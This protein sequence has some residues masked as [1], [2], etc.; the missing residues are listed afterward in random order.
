MP[1]Q[2][3]KGVAMSKSKHQT[4]GA[5][6]DFG[7]SPHGLSADHLEVAG[8]NQGDV[9][10]QSLQDAF[11]VRGSEESDRQN[12]LDDT[13]PLSRRK[14][15]RRGGVS[16]SHLLRFHYLEMEEVEFL[17][18]FFAVE[19]DRR[20]TRK[21]IRKGIAVDEDLK[22]SDSLWNKLCEIQALRMGWKS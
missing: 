16:S 17:H 13:P 21:A 5:D 18:V 22:A 10:L 20:R 6:F 8:K 2:T 14:E 12:W 15:A 4:Q 3:S 9:N 7:T 11:A 19:Q 1:R